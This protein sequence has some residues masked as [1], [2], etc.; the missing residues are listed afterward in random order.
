MAASRLNNRFTPRAF[1]D[2]YLTCCE[3]FGSIPTKVSNP[4]QVFLYLFE[5]FTLSLVSP[6]F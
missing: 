2:R 4:T 6:P 5:G 1:P 3:N